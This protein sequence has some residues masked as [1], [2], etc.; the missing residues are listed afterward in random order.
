MPPP[1]RSLN[2]ALRER[3]ARRGR[4][5]KFGNSFPQTDA[6][7][8][9]ATQK[10]LGRAASA[11]ARL[12]TVAAAPTSY[13]QPLTLWVR[14]EPKRRT[15]AAGVFVSYD[16]NASA[17]AAIP[18]RGRGS[19]KTKYRAICTHFGACACVPNRLP[20]LGRAGSR[21]HEI[22]HSF[23]A[24]TLAPWDCAIRWRLAT[25]VAS[26]V[27]GA[28]RAT[29]RQPRLFTSSTRKSVSALAA[30]RRKNQCG[31]RI[32]RRSQAGTLHNARRGQVVIALAPGSGPKRRPVRPPC[33]GRARRS[34][35]SPGW[36]KC[37]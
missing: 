29:R 12:T 14:L 27:P 2:P 33:P 17:S 16:L 3:D 37:E 4:S 22:A 18:T 19:G 32:A 6:G 13:T 11:V 31:V 5:C 20:R 10:L 26:M 34:L 25:P 21:W 1:L 7:Y 23:L 9:G 28:G 35:Q 8:L 30:R 36:R 24:G 15:A